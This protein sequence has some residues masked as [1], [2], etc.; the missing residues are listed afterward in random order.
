MT[1]KNLIL[2]LSMFSSSLAFA[3]TGQGSVSCNQ[4]ERLVAVYTWFHS[5]ADSYSS[6]TVFVQNSN[7]GYDQYQGSNEQALA[8]IAIRTN[9][10]RLITVT[11]NLKN[12]NCDISEK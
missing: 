8:S 10:G 2:A 11:P 3:G 7:G 9:D 6:V 1:M 12:S 4:D 5:N